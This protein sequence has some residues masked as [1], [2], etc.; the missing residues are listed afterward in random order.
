M[1]SVIRR[2]CIALS[3]VDVLALRS[4]LPPPHVAHART[5]A[6]IAGSME[7]KEKRKARLDRTRYTRKRHSAAL[8]FFSF[9]SFVL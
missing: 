2:K 8:L 4:L 3:Y 5:Q 7:L 1:R 6:Y 9:L